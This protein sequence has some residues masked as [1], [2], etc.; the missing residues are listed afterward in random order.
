M[1]TKIL[2]YEYPYF[3]TNPHI[4]EKC[5]KKRNARLFVHL[6]SSA[7]SLAVLAFF[8]YRSKE[9]DRHQKHA[10]GQNLDHSIILWEITMFNG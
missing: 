8:S 10:M 2:I 5:E 1:F 4:R 7:S 9:N 6:A 3:Q